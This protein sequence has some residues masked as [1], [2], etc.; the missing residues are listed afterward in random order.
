MVRIVF[1]RNSDIT[2]EQLR[3]ATPTQLIAAQYGVPYPQLL[4]FV[5]NFQVIA[6]IG[7]ISH[8]EAVDFNNFEQIIDYFQGSTMGRRNEFITKL[9]I[10][11]T[12]NNRINGLHG[13][14]EDPFIENALFVQNQLI[15]LNDQTIDVPT[16]APTLEPTSAPSTNDEHPIANSSSSAIATNQLIGEEF[17]NLNHGWIFGNHDKYI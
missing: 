11:T 16:A 9:V 3:N 6:L 17:L 7:N 12:F 5:N 10:Y 15:A 4:N 8:E 2:P 13:V 14:R 1:I